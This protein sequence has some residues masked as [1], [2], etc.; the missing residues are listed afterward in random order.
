MKVH[1]HHACFPVY[2]LLRFIA[3]CLLAAIPAA[4]TPETRGDPA[5]AA[6]AGWWKVSYEDSVLGTVSGAAKFDTDPNPEVPLRVTYRHPLTGKEYDLKASRAGIRQNGKRITIVLEGE[7]PP[8]QRVLPPSEQNLLILRHRKGEHLI[9]RS[10]GID[11]DAPVGAR[12]DVDWNRVELHLTLQNRTSLDGT[13]EYRAH[14]TTERDHVGYGPVG[15]FTPDG[16]S[17]R[18]GTQKGEERWVRTPEIEGVIVLT[19]PLPYPFPGWIG[20]GPKDRTL[21][22][23][24]KNLPMEQDARL[25]FVSSDPGIRYAR[26]PIHGSTLEEGFL[27]MYEMP[28]LRAG[29][30]PTAEQR[31]TDP[32]ALALAKERAKESDAMVFYAE[33]EDGI[34]AG[35]KTLLLNGAPAS[36]ALEFLDLGANAHFVRETIADQY[37]LARSAYSPDELFLEIETEFRVPIDEIPVVV[38]VGPKSACTLAASRL[39]N[40]EKY[41]TPPFKILS[42][43]SPGARSS[44]SSIV[45][46]PGAA[47]MATEGENS[48]ITLKQPQPMIPVIGDIRVVIRPQQGRWQSDESIPSVTP[49]QPFFVEVRMPR[50]Q[51]QAVGQPTL[52]IAFQNKGTR[53]GGTLTLSSD[54]SPWD[55]PVVFTTADPLTVAGGGTGEGGYVT[56]WGGKIFRGDMSG[57]RFQ[58]ADTIEVSY[59]EASV[60]FQVYDTWVQQRLAHNIRFLKELSQAYN[61]CLGVPNLSE[62][63]KEAL[64]LK[65][66]LIT[67]AMRIM[68]RFPDDPHKLHVSEAYIGMLQD[69]GSEYAYKGSLSGEPDPAY[70]AIWTSNEER[71]AVYTAKRVGDEHLGDLFH[72]LKVDTAIACYWAFTETIGADSLVMTVFGINNMGEKVGLSER[73]FGFLDLI[74]RAGIGMK[75]GMRKG[76]GR[77]GKITGTKRIGP[78][79]LLDESMDEA[80]RVRAPEEKLVAKAGDRTPDLDDTRPARGAKG[81]PEPSAHKP[82]DQTPKTTPPKHTPEPDQPGPRDQGPMTEPT[83][84]EPAP[85]VREPPP[86][87]PQVGDAPARGTTPAPEPI[88]PEPAPTAH[89]PRPARIPD[90]DIVTAPLEPSSRPMPEGPRPQPVHPDTT[91]T[92]HVPPPRPSATEPSH[93]AP[94]P[95]PSARYTPPSFSDVPDQPKSVK[96]SPDGTRPKSITQDSPDNLREPTS[97]PR[98]RSDVPDADKTPLQSAIDEPAHHPDIDGTP[99]QV[100]PT[101]SRASAT[102]LDPASASSPHANRQLKFN[103]E[104]GE[105]ISLDTAD[106][107]GGGSTSKAYASAASEG[108]VIRVTDVTGN[109]KA[110]QL[111]EFGRKVLTE[112]V[113]ADAVRVV[114][115]YESHVVTDTADAALRGK[116]VE[117]VERITPAHTMLPDQ[118]GGTMTLGQAKAFDR[119]TRELNAKGFAWLDNHPGN[120]GFEKLPGEDNWRVVVL[121]PGGI[122]PMKGATPAARAESARALQGAINNPSA[123]FKSD[124]LTYGNNPGVKLGLL[125][126][127]RRKILDAHG[128]N[129]DAKAMGLD[130]P[131][132][133]AFTPGG[134]V[135]FD[136]VQRLFP[137]TADEARHFQPPGTAP[138][139][140]PGTRPDG[141]HTQRMEPAPTLRD[142]ETTPG[143]R[144]SP[145]ARP[146][147]FKTSRLEPG[148]TLRD[149][150]MI[151]G[152]RPYTRSRPDGF[153][154]Q[155]VPEPTEPG[156]PGRRTAELAEWTNDVDRR[157]Y[158][159]PEGNLAPRGQAIDAG[160]FA[161]VHATP[162][163]D[164]SPSRVTKFYERRLGER[165]EAQAMVRDTRCG[166]DA[167]KEAGVRQ[168]E[169][170]VCRTDA[171]IPYVRQR[172]VGHDLPDG[173]R[174][175]VTYHEACEIVPE[176]DGAKRFTIKDPYQEGVLDVYEDMIRGGLV[177]EDIRVP[178][179]AWQL[180][181]DAA[182][183]G[184][185]RWT[186]AILDQDRIAHMMDGTPITKTDRGVTR[187]FELER[188]KRAFEETPQLHG[189]ASAAEGGMKI[190]DAREFMFRMLERHKFIQFDKVSGTF[191]SGALDIGRVRKRFEKLGVNIDDYITA[192]SRPT[193]HI[194]PLRPGFAMF[195]G[196]PS[197][198]R[199]DGWRARHP[200]PGV[201]LAA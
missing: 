88:A 52:D 90:D 122:V 47:I 168:I 184:G 114:E 95:E 194:L 130:S 53:S 7:S 126:D 3:P 61:Q 187:H 43:D 16:D 80:L 86:R 67:N 89:G 176:V 59:A 161:S 124:I 46:R 144:L 24:G 30:N 108:K 191:K 185:Q 160:G 33:F 127:Q 183:P 120:Y 58:N 23:F 165:R 83:S 110:R 8:S 201:A 60:E 6:L 92:T 167:L 111:D 97:Q 140:M 156:L 56:L 36:W 179:L 181:D 73:F 115:R 71:Q 106:Y 76:A 38:G 94:A 129:I 35:P 11:R 103:N 142:P 199:A 74:D 137:L 18:A 1:C 135:R 150:E 182:A 51:A 82:A 163:P 155:P 44:G 117:V 37:E 175:E 158:I 145:D 55:N 166:A 180:I 57:L 69:G 91:P 131:R 146:N 20:A 134:V 65:L 189:I 118:P 50:Q 116:T 174:K 87:G 159:D 113:D 85:T 5:T 193:S 112:N 164:G 31:T 177:G 154:T 93:M 196:A 149:P 12:G 2:S 171:A 34:L 186:A 10:E 21:F 170:D 151:R 153:Q 15:T 136:D 123:E 200:M 102:A 178:N 125:I 96:P 68:D 121:D 169:I 17:C 141:F 132:D 105:S 45:A 29:Y 78:V 188:A 79:M 138:K 64:H 139:P 197:I 63:D 162:G 49:E 119:A 40:S 72:R 75:L 42:P 148:P 14:P 41:R 19:K 133:V 4:A 39:G 195:H 98:P 172:R 147:G 81:T 62:D 54:Y 22:I 66:R 28:K 173:V 109:V 27:E 157:Y 99:A 107:L 77:L 48:L 25:E 70:G 198:P 100:D 13:W 84:P 143:D 128:H 190:Q 152:D 32:A 192:G 104:T 101:G 26:Y 9:A